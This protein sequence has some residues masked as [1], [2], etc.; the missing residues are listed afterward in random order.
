MKKIAIIS[1][2]S[3]SCGNAYF[4]QVLLDS[5][6]EQGYEAE[7]VSLNLLLTQSTNRDIRIKADKHISDI[8]MKLKSFDGVNIQFEA[9]LYGT[10]PSDIYKRVMK[11]SLANPNTSVTLHSPRLINDSAS[12]REV[13]KLLMLRIKS[14]IGLY[15]K[16]LRES[17]SKRIN[18]RI[19]KKLAGNKI[20]LIVH[21]LRAKE[22]IELM[23]NYDNVSVHPLKLVPES[24][25]INENIIQ[26]I[27]QSYSFSKETKIIGVFGFVN[28][29]KGHSLAIQA[30]EYL[31]NNYKLMF[32]GRQHP[33]TI[34]NNELVNG[35]I[36][37]LQKSIINKKLK[38]RVFF[39]GE[40]GN[41]EFIS[42][43]ATVDF[44]W[45]PYVENGQDGSGI[46][47][48]CFD[49]AKRVLCSSSFAFD[50]MLKL[51]SSYDNYMRFD[52]GNYLELS[53]KTAYFHPQKS[54]ATKIESNYTVATQA[55]L[56]IK[57]SLLI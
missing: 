40:Y 46:A 1:S 41:D 56:Y 54:I 42:L 47:A 14:G 10:L 28:E 33:Q 48:I 30:M 45:L 6:R 32:F 51:I 12:Q 5:I 57:K 50:E 16:S 18:G 7:C 31:P 23:Y 8:C 44:V 15:F 37:S 25:N 20:N 13:I 29:Y 2:F 53:N 27:K 19:I 38:S 52:I 11:L 34:K 36:A 39:M 24:P 26:D 43:A 21:T 9:G 4:T 17:V 22:Q 55:S 49:V 3:E 35:Y